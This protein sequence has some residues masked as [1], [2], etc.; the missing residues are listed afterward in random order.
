MQRIRWHTPVA[1]QHTC[2]SDGDTHYLT[3]ITCIDGYQGG[4][5]QRCIWCNS[6]TAWVCA[7]C[8]TGPMALV[9]LCP[10]ITKVRKGQYGGV[11]VA[12]QCLGRHRCNPT[13][14]PKGKRG[15][16]RAKRARGMFS[17]PDEEE[18]A[19]DAEDAEE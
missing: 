1:G 9:P 13:F 15:G 2:S 18:F 10:E 5:Q 17:D 12:H 8:T 16:G 11:Q 14:F 6:K 19:E 7:T 3:K 4:K